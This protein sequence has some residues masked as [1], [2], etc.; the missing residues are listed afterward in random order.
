MSK[1]D[2]TT[3]GW[4][5]DTDP[6]VT[7]PTKIILCPATCGAVKLSSS[8]VEVLLGCKTIIK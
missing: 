7:P 6:S 2:A 3:G 5:Y 1:C 8:P 4:Y